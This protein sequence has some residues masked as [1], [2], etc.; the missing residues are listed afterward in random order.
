MVEEDQV[1]DILDYNLNDV[2]ATFEFFKHTMPAIRLRLSLAEEFDNPHLLN[3]ND[4]KIG[5]EIFA[6]YLSEDMGISK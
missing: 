1:D 3:A 6:H 2:M 4:A 5:S